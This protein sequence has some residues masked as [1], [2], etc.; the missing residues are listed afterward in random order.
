MAEKRN[1]QPP[2]DG[3]YDNRGW[4]SGKRTPLVY[5]AEPLKKPLGWTEVIAVASIVVAVTQATG[6]I[7]WLIYLKIIVGFLTGGVVP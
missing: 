3:Y 5:H 1:Y 4:W 2:G 7:D 6:W